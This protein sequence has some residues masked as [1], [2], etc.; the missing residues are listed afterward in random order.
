MRTEQQTLLVACGL[1]RRVGRGEIG[2][3]RHAGACGAAS[4]DGW[5]CTTPRIRSSPGSLP[6]RR[7]CESRASSSTRT[8]SS[9]S[10]RRRPCST[11]GLPAARRHRRRD[12]AGARQQRRCSRPEAR[13]AG[14]SRRSSSGSLAAREFRFSASRSSST[15]RTSSGLLR[16]YPSTPE[17]AERI[18]RSPLRR[19]FLG[20][21]PEAVRE[22]VLRT[23]RGTRTAAAVLAGAAVRRPRR[24]PA[25]RD[26]A[27]PARTS[28]SHSTHW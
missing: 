9:W 21:R 2:C 24:G 20:P 3:A 25:P 8:S 4:T 23:L 11:A 18:A 1:A 16:G 17:A 27:A 14:A 10:A 22:R 28:T 26:G 7:G 19:R 13:R 12:A 6:A 5:R 15:T